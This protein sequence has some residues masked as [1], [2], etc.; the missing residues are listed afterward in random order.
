[1]SAEKMG[2][3]R[4]QG[5]RGRPGRAG[6]AGTLRSRAGRELGRKLLEE[7]QR[8]RKAGRGLLARSYM[9][10]DS[11]A[12]LGIA[13]KLAQLGVV[14]IPLDFLPLDVV[15]PKKYSDRPY[16]SYESKFIAAAEI[17]ADDPKLYGLAA[18]QLR[19]RPELVHP[20]GASKTSWAASPWASSKSTSTP[21]RPGW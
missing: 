17:I 2:F 8:E 13:E 11:G 4:R 7:L 1:M 3:S 21:P 18:D 10:Q 19:L 6:V 14:P 16:W 5:K 12:N 9:S 20:A 15:D